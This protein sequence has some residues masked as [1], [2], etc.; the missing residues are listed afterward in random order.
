[1]LPL[2]ADWGYERGVPIDRYYIERF[3]ESCA[4]DVRGIVLEI[5]EP[6]YTRRFGGDRV[7]RSDVIDIDPGNQRA[8]LTGDLRRL[9]AIPSDTYDCFIL[10]QTVHV[11]NDMRTVLREAVRI[12]KPGGVLLVTFPYASRVCLEYGP[13]GDFWR[14]TEAGARQLF[15]ELL[16]STHVEIQSYGNVLTNTAFLEGI[17][18][19]EISPEEFESYDPFNPMLVSVRAVKPLPHAPPGPR[20][21]AAGSAAILL[22]HRIATPAVD[23]HGLSVRPED[24]RAHLAHLA[25][26]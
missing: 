20:R 3:L 5:Q 25:K 16:P 10:T 7:V 23:I 1:V 2:S 4:G 24:F 9:E 14:V 22:Y 18:C 13:D 26:E 17:A 21:A 6:D 12:L 11:I 15:S 8:N 19:D